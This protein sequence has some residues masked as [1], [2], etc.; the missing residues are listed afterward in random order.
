RQL[1]PKAEARAAALERKAG[2]HPCASCPDRAKHER[3]AERASKLSHEVAALEQRI[4][5]RTETLGRQF[6]RVVAV[7]EDLGYVEGFSLTAKGEG[8]RRIYA[9]GDILVS[10]SLAEGLFD[11]LSPSEVA[12]LV[13]AFVYESREREPSRPHIPTGAL[14]DRLR[15]LASLWTRIRRVE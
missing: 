6:D 10:E 11:G 14:R 13:S 2:R 5:R 7:L 1:D 12:A 8:L 15:A 4:R 9:E 3:W